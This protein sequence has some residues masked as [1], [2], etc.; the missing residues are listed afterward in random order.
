MTLGTFHAQLSTAV[1]IYALVAG[2]WSLLNYFR[3]I[4]EIDG[5][6]WGILAIAE[7]LFLAQG[8]V[9][10]IL[11]FAGARPDRGIHILYGVVM[12]IALPGYYSYSRGRDDRR[13][14]GTYALICLFLA[15]IAFRAIGTG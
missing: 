6:T 5:R 13:A 1:W 2:L 15:G 7:L 9:G 14:M 4:E 8:I 10:S 12:A 3:K 11:F